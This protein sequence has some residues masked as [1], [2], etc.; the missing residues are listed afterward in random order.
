M[1]G[2]AGAGGRRLC[3]APGFVTARCASGE[4]A[5]HSRTGTVTHGGAV[6]QAI[7]LFAHRPNDCSIMFEL[8]LRQDQAC[9]ILTAACI[10][11]LTIHQ[12][13]VSISQ[14]SMRA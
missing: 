14:C 4:Q 5:N 1:E 13:H 12:I 3:T 8:V 9:R 11:S 10:P 6:M 7:V 2:S